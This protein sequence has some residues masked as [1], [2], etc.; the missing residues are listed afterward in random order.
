MSAIIGAAISFT[1]AA[2]SIVAGV[3]L[4]AGAGWACIAY[5]IACLIFCVVVIR[6]LHSGGA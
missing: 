5:G 1:M 6:G 2:G 3:Y 4:L